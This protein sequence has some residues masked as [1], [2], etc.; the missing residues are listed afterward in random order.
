M[1]CPIVPR[2]TSGS[3]DR[4]IDTKTSVCWSVHCPHR[5]KWNPSRPTALCSNTPTESV[6]S[7]RDLV[8]TTPL[9]SLVGSV[10]ISIGLS[11]ES[12][13]DDENV[14]NS[15]KRDCVFLN[16]AVDGTT[17]GTVVIEVL[18]DGPPVGKKRFIDLCRGVE[19]VGYRRDKVTEI[20]NTHVVVGQLK[21]LSFRAD[22]RTGVAGGSTTEI[23]EDELNASTRRHD[24]PGV[25][26]LV[27][28]PK[29]EF[30]SQ[31]KLVAMNGKFITTTTTFGLP[32]NGTGLNICLDKAPELDKTSLVVGHVV[33][34]M[35]VIER[36]SKLPRV[37]DNDDSVFFKAGKA[38]G[39]RR[40]NVAEK[41]FGRPF[42]KI[43][44]TESGIIE[45]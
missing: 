2:R 23:L 44:I 7:R 29:K 10:L 42:A 17:V 33:Q 26:S 27:V 38:A 41:A 32:P 25:V 35:D 43:T 34:G 4:I 40:A 31:D 9:Q 6:P 20:R 45:N 22:G 12:K 24:G 37:K 3:F 21:A 18:E 28:N 11:L 14:V 1:Y 30:E 15:T 8:V 36:L 19:G 39:D 5:G 13:A 16:F